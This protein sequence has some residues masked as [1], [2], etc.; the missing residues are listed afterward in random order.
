[1]LDLLPK[2]IK[3]K[4]AEVKHTQLP[5]NMYFFSV[6]DSESEAQFNPNGNDSN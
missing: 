2:L 3:G 4:E 5:G 1:M 6:C